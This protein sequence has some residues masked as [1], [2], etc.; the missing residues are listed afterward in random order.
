MSFL[1][2]IW[3]G[4][5]ITSFLL[6]LPLLP[7]SSLFGVAAAARRAFYANGLCKSEGPVVPVVVVGGITVG[8]SGKTPICI[9]LV[10]ELRARGFNPGVLSRGYKAKGAQFPAQVPLDAD[11]VIYGD[12]PCLIRRETGAPVV[13]DPQRNRGADYLVGLGVDLIIT[14]DGL[15]HYALDRDVEICVLDGARMLGN[16]HLLP[17]GPLREARWRLKTVDTVVVSGAVAHLGYFPMVLKQSSIV[18]LNLR[19]HEVL[20]PKSRV[21]ALAGIGN[22]DRFYKT[23]E[24]CGFTVAE[25]VD[26]GDHDRIDYERLAALASK[27]P[28]VMTSKDAIKYQSEAARNNLSNVFVLNVTAHLSKQF[29]D[30]V[31]GKVKQSRSRVEKRLNEREK[32]GYIRPEIDLVDSLEEVAEHNAR[33]AAIHAN[34]NPSPAAAPMTPDT[35]PAIAPEDL[36]RDADNPDAHYDSGAESVHSEYSAHDSY[37]NGMS[38]SNANNDSAHDGVHDGAHQCD[39]AH[40]GDDD[41]EGKEHKSLKKSLKSKSSRSGDD[42][43]SDSPDSAEEQNLT[44]TSTT[45]AASNATGADSSSSSRSDAVMGDDADDNQSDQTDKDD[46]ADTAG[47]SDN[48]A[49]SAAGEAKGSD[50]SVCE[51]INDHRSVKA[52][53]DGKD[54]FSLKKQRRDFDPD[55]LPRELKRRK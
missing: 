53:D 51:S 43:S 54:I 22:P 55:A 44:E 40:H 20:Q 24:D 14:D 13:I 7:F 4:R 18:P 52:H 39:D 45:G 50:S 2:N 30:D 32:A 31:V 17:A 3:Y 9:A 5:N 27:G 15:Q 25:R 26:V 36:E 33:W 49:S 41:G 21:I 6:Q 10:K 35:A 8:G 34:T 1:N 38:S 16:G 11:P 28:V 46:K 42:D 29:Y 23:L 47:Q 12:E 48:A 37:E 19:S